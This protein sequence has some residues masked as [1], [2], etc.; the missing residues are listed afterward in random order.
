MLDIPEEVLT[1]CGP[2]ETFRSDYKAA[3]FPRTRPANAPVIEPTTS[4]FLREEIE[5]PKDCYY[6]ES[7]HLALQGNQDYLNMLETVITLQAQRTQ[8]I[9]DLETL[10]VAKQKALEMDALLY[11]DKLQRGEHPEYPGPQ[12]IVEIPEIDW[13]KYHIFRPDLFM[14]PQTRHTNTEPIIKHAKIE[15]D[16]K[17]T[18]VK[19][20][21]HNVTKPETFGQKWTCEEQQKLEELLRKYPSEEIEMNRF[22]KIADALGKKVFNLH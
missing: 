9:K 22:R 1:G 6:F 17:T 13:S 11:V 3:A 21:P 12:K 16:T 2:E 19:N 10:L 4:I 15:E 8:A 7:D 5:D 20:K 18:A 14:R